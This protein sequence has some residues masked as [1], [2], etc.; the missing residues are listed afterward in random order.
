[1]LQQIFHPIN[2]KLF[3]FD[4]FILL[5]SPLIVK[6]IDTTHSSTYYIQVQNLVLVLHNQQWFCVIGTLTAKSNT[7]LKYFA[8]LAQWADYGATPH[9]RT[10]KVYLAAIY[11]SFCEALPARA[12][13]EAHGRWSRRCFRGISQ[14]FYFYDHRLS[15]DE[16]LS[17][18]PCD[19]SGE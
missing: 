10:T 14:V 2:E 3:S 15:H 7:L 9:R 17:S 12:F 1:M 11:E 6:E 18:S 4:S 5:F 8:Y 16:C 13:C 19:Y